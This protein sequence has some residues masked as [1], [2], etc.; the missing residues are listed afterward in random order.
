MPGWGGN[1]LD[2][3]TTVQPYADPDK[4]AMAPD[5]VH[6]LGLPMFA[7]A[8]CSDSKEV[9]QQAGIEAALTLMTDALCGANIVHDLGYLESGLTGSLAQLVICDEILDWLQH[10]VRGV[11]IDDE[12]LALDLIDE[13]GPD[14]QFLQSEHTLQHFRE[15]WYPGLFD[16]NNYDS[17]LAKGGQT[18]GQRAAE[19]VQA[20]L[21]QHQPEPLPPDVSRAVH[22]I[23]ERAEIDR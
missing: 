16:R 19:R 22:A 17:W 1:M 12:T 11:E 9:D 14:G 7:L 2:M 15:R 10:F 3:R 21:S 20:I 6:Y 13:I 8:G 18:L 5:F 4:R 23:I